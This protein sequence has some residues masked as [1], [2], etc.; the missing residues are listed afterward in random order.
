MLPKAGRIVE[1]NWLVALRIWLT[2]S[3]NWH[4]AFELS[5]GGGRSSCSSELH[6]FEILIDRRVGHF[7]RHGGAVEATWS[8]F[9]QH[10]TQRQAARTVNYSHNSYSLPPP[11]Y[12]A[13]MA[14]LPILPY[15]HNSYFTTL[16]DATLLVPS[17]TVQNSLSIAGRMCGRHWRPC[18]LI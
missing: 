15:S 17:I 3:L 5:S 8:E 9:L 16:L 7:V 13:I 2:I 10:P 4:K 14:G 18:E 1:C 6:L 11:S 12:Y